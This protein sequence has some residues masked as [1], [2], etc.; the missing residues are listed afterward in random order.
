MNKQSIKTEVDSIGIVFPAYIAHLYGI[1][2]IAERFKEGT[3]DGS[4]FLFAPP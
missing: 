1:P 4:L 2:L 3:G